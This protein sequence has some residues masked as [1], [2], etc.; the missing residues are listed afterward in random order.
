[1]PTPRSPRPRP[2]DPRLLQHR[3]HDLAAWATTHTHTGWLWVEAHKLPIDAGLGV[4][5]AA[6][7]CW[8]L[9]GRRGDT[10]RLGRLK[11]TAAQR[12]LSEAVRPLVGYPSTSDAAPVEKWP[13]HPGREGA[14]IPIRCHS[15]FSPTERKIAAVA[16]AVSWYTR[17]HGGEWLP[18]Y[19][20]NS[21]WLRFV[22][23]APPFEWPTD[24]HYDDLT[25]P[26]SELIRLGVRDG[27]QQF[28]WDVTIPM[29]AHALIGG[30]T[31]A[32]KSNALRIVIAEFARLGALIDIIDAKGGEDFEDFAEHPGIR[33]WTDTE[34]M[35]AVLA[36]F[37]A[38]MDARRPTRGAERTALPRRVLIIDET[39]EVKTAVRLLGKTGT[40]YVPTLLTIARLARSVRMHLVCATQKPAA[41]ALTGD[42]VTGAEL[43]DLLGFKL[44]LG[45]L[46]GSAANMM[47]DA[48]PPAVDG[49]VPGRGVLHL[50]GRFTHVQTAR[51]EL[52]DAV[53]VA[54]EGSARFPA[55]PAGQP[56]MPEWMTATA[57]LP[58]VDVDNVDGPRPGVA[59]L[60]TPSTP[61]ATVP[62]QCRACR[63]RWAEPDSNRGKVV[64]CKDAGCRRSRRVPV[65]GDGLLTDDAA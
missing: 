60:S 28:G 10:R 58:V 26:D 39:A 32:G 3:A 4:T 34:D 46:S 30:T 5:V 41:K 18:D 35:L 55:G 27:G 22:R 38:E 19:D 36:E 25:V 43:R 9:A 53:R 17:R 2:V 16:E 54:L 21:K 33:V 59:A 14:T 44:G 50:N 62:M 6:A 23:Q 45:Q 64:K 47:F 63:Q 11:R 12:S 65:A 51:L 52:A 48:E 1:V 42:P 8:L 24:L 49:I 7:G 56:V 61:V 40:E 20:E 37:R 31:G 15:S 13:K 57:P 29:H